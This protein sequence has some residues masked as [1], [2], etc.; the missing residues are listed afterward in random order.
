MLSD[1]RVSACLVLYHQ[2]QSVQRTARCIAESTEPVELYIVDNS[3]E[4]ITVRF[5]QLECPEATVFPQKKNLG[6]GKANNLVL[7]KL[8]SKYHLILN[9]D[10]T[11]DR[12]LIRRMVD[13]MDAHPDIVILSPNSFSPAAGRLY[14]IFWE[15]P[16]SVSENH[17]R[18]GAPHL[19]WQIRKSPLR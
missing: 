8:H 19:P 1:P 17:S 16:W 14:D 12:T 2:D 4:D 5:V 18:P 11:F 3:P 15:V 10:V 9:P 6:Y 7:N 13:Y